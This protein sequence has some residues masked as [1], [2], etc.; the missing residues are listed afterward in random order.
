MGIGQSLRWFERVG[1]VAGTILLA[2]CGNGA[3]ARG[4]TT[5][6]PSVVSLN[7]CT[8]AILVELEHPEILA[9]SH[10]SHDLRSSSLPQNVAMQYAV[11]GGTVEEVLALDP[12]RVLASPFMAPATQNGLRDLNIP[13][14]TFGS[15]GNVEDSK[16]QIERLASLIRAPD[17]GRSLTRSID[18]ALTQYAAP[19]GYEPIST[20]LWQSG[21]IVAGEQ[22]LIAQLMQQAGF[23]SHS[24]KLGLGQADRLSLEQV[25]ANPPD[26][27]LITGDSTGQNHPLLGKLENTRIE[28]F[29]PKLLYCGGPTIIAA[30]ERLAAI[31][32]QMR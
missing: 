11:T 22:T 9:L 12:D 18:L 19:T 17:A 8:D 10:Y 29:D 16:A 14:A 6:R 5:E 7:P 25:L 20:V 1:I 30:M 23:A 3:D 21:E 13:L 15:P 32:E 27:L 2:A 24:Q 26:L 28:R 31:R 4:E